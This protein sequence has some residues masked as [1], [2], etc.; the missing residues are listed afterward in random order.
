[1]PTGPNHGCSKLRMFWRRLVGAVAIYALVM[2]PLLLTIAGGQLA[3]ASVV[4]EVALAQL[5][6][7][8]SD[9]SPT[10]P[11]NHEQHPADQHCLQC[12][13][14]AFHLFD[15]PEPAAVAFAGRE[16]RKLRPAGQ[17]LQLSSSSPYSIA[18]PR[19]PPL[20]A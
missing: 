12:F 17:P 5:C 13:T 4:D 20:S 8:N 3:Q 10:E 14:G 7:H 19:G 9:G 16:F 15:A 6:Q 2:Q 1:M 11:S 18:S